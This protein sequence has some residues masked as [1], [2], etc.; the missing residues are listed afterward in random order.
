MKEAIEKTFYSLV[1]VDSVSKNEGAVAALVTDR[2]TALGFD[3][4][5]D[6]I[7]NI[8]GFL[9]GTG[10]PIL[11]NA[12]LDGVPPG[13]GHIPVKN[14]D[15]LKSDGSTNLRADDVA[16][17]AIILEAA[18]VIVTEQK[19]HPPL[20]VAFTVQE[21]IGL[22]GAKALNLAEYGVTQ[23]IVFDNAFEAGS[24]VSQG[25]AYVA[26]DVEI[27][28]KETHPGKDLTQGANAIQVLI[29]TGIR[30]GEADNGKTRI[31]I[32]TLSAGKARN[33]VPG[34]LTLQGE[35]RS[36]LQGQELK[37]RVDQLQSAFAEAANR[38]GAEV[39]FSTKQLALAYKVDPNEPLLQ[40]YKNVV[41]QRSGT[42]EMKE[43]F[44]ASDANALRGEKGLNVFVVSTGVKNEH[45]V[46]ETVDL[47]ELE[48]LGKDLVKV[49]ELASKI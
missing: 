35:V 20:V 44:V 15:I 48:Q 39:K 5:R 17:V 18:N 23:G 28:G 9:T 32:G 4:K 2:L 16:G 47:S 22:W 14:G 27:I 3:T 36:F 26:F 13:K 40:T 11:L 49:L 38:N 10:Q 43:T 29:D 21:E 6:E 30:A 8:I 31:N 1:K 42:F 12:H 37:A 34:N 24:V 45:S 41:E 25:S 7:G 19:A 46:E 33:V